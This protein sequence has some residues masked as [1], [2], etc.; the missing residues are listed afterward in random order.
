MR[1]VLETIFRHPIQIVLLI[2]APTLIG[3]TIALAQP[4]VYEAS[5]TL[6]ANQRY[7]IIGATG[8]EADLSATPAS[9]QATAIME[10]LQTRSFAL[11]VASQTD[12]R[13]TMDAATRSNADTLNDALFSEISKNVKVTPIGGYLYQITYDNQHPKIAQ[14]VVASVVQTFGTVAMNFSTA[15]AEQLLAS[16]TDQLT[17]AQAVATTSGQKAA[18]YLNQHPNATTAKDPLYTQLYNQAQADQVAVLTI[19]GKIAQV[20]QQISTIGSNSNQ[21]YRVIDAP[22]V[23]D[24]P[25]SRVKTVGLGAGI[26]VAV[27]LLGCTIYLVMLLRQDRTVYGPAELRRSTLLPVLLELPYLQDLQGA[28]QLQAVSG[29]SEPRNRA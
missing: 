3:T 20:N 5:A 10:L 23:N 26:G 11:A 21:L 19:R 8:P 14:Q 27:A 28:K 16:Y 2:L 4:R 9:T 29:R 7:A 17:R 1:R 22:S 12:L 25:V 24:R 18:D 15:E 6:W 13:S